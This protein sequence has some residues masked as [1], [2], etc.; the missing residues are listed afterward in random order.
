MNKFF[1]EKLLDRLE[2]STIEQ[3]SISSNEIASFINESRDLAKFGEVRIALENLLENMIEVDA[4]FSDE[5]IEIATKAF[6]DNIPEYDKKLLDLI[7]N[8]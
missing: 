2:I 4:V 5:L 3:C 7:Q 6:G 8:K 1:F